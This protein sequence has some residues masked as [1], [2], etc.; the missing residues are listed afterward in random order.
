[1][2]TRN[3]A[4]DVIAKYSKLIKVTPGKKYSAAQTKDAFLRHKKFSNKEEAKNEF[5]N[6]NKEIRRKAEV[7][8]IV[9]DRQLAN[10]SNDWLGTAIRVVDTLKEAGVKGL[11]EDDQ[12][13]PVGNTIHQAGMDVP[14]R[15]YNTIDQAKVDVPTDN[16]LTPV[17]KKTS[18]AA[19][20][21]AGP[22]ARRKMDTNTEVVSKHESPAPLQRP[23]SE[24]M[25]PKSG[26]S[27]E[28]EVETALQIQKNDR[29]IHTWHRAVDEHGGGNTEGAGNIVASNGSD[30]ESDTKDDSPQKQQEH[31]TPEP[32]PA[33]K[34]P[35][36]QTPVRRPRSEAAG[37]SP[38]GGGGPG[39]DIEPAHDRNA[40][41][42]RPAD[43]PPDGGG[44]GGGA[45]GRVEQGGGRPRGHYSDL[46]KVDDAK[47]TGRSPDWGGKV[48]GPLKKEEL[49]YQM[50]HPRMCFR[51]FQKDNYENLM[52][53]MTFSQED[54]HMYPNED[55]QKECGDPQQAFS[56]NQQILQNYGRTLQIQSLL[57]DPTKDPN[58]DPL[59]ICKEYLELHEATRVALKRY[60]KTTKGD[61]HQPDGMELGL[62]EFNNQ[63][64]DGSLLGYKRARS[65]ASES[66][67]FVDNNKFAPKLK[68]TKL[69]IRRA[70]QRLE[71]Y[72]YKWM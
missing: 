59:L 51:F 64:A 19:G 35:D 61:Y 72:T 62:R 1:M 65:S 66:Q 13:T 43:G 54:G 31:K 9:T 60:M 47:S 28:F 38:D 11:T 6:V 52:K 17:Q 27:T 12:K 70:P 36:P 16:P 4:E 42:D 69:Q 67:S 33:P 8:E 24:Y 56:A 46:R 3:A 68:R 50:C 2:A 40:A 5:D 49:A 14:T 23:E 41:V 20:A 15:Q 48:S 10:P 44:G 7:P 55:G 37:A 25:T 39:A 71:T 58:V 32:A 63:D 29:A 30:T 34:G 45:P 26:R 18:A 21:N 57:Y 53:L 22:K